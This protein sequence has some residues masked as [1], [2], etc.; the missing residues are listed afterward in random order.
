MGRLGRV[1]RRRDGRVGGILAEAGEQVA[2]GGFEIGD[3]A[4]EFRDVPIA[5]LASGAEGFSHEFSIAGVGRGS[6]ARSSGERLQIIIFYA[7]VEL[8]LNPPAR[9]G[10]PEPFGIVGEINPSF[11]DMLSCRSR[12]APPFLRSQCRIRAGSVWA[13]AV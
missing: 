6:C 12:L 10:P 2:D 4:F 9:G 8:P 3:A 1:G 13:S 11:R 7:L 5:L